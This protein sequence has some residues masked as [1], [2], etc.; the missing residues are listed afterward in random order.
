MLELLGLGADAETAYRAML[1]NPREG[2]AELGERLG[3][4]SERVRPALDELARLSLLRSSSEVP[5]AHRLVSPEVGL[6]SLLARQEAELLERQ[7]QIATSRSAVAE[8]VAEYADLRQIRQH[9]EMEQLVGLDA[10]RTRIEELARGCRSQVLGFAAGGA[11]TPANMEASRPLDREFLE[12]GRDMRTIYLDSVRNDPASVDYIRWLVEL[13]AQVRTVPSLPLR[14]T[15]FDR[16]TAL[17]P[18]NPERSEV[19]AVLLHGSGM[20]AA[21]CALFDQIWRTASEFGTRPRRD[22]DG[23]TAQEQEVLRLL[24]QGHTDEAVARQ[25]GVSVRTGRRI[26]AELM[27]RL[28]A[29][30]R[31]QAG[32]RAAENGWLRD[33]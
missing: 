28:G 31:F 7:R 15:V 14:M 18:V 22:G 32:A 11:Q 21:L 16:R 5:G 17:I 33:L 30:S 20:V 2:I 4:P 23:L 26:T 25:L 19:G 3:W 8:V 27:E 13:G 12:Q 10:V 9:P 6:V 24:A 29:R 1:E